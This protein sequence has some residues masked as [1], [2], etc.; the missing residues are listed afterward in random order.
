M[1]APE[2]PGT[3]IFC[4]DLEFLGT[5]EDALR[6]GAVEVADR[7]TDH[8]YVDDLLRVTLLRIARNRQRI[9]QRDHRDGARIVGN[10][11]RGKILIRRAGPVE[12]TRHGRAVDHLRALG[13]QRES[14]PGRYALDVLVELVSEKPGGVE[15]GRSLVAKS[16]GPCRK[17]GHRTAFVGDAAFD[18]DDIGIVEGELLADGEILIGI[19]EG[20]FLAV[21]ARPRTA[22]IRVFS[23]RRRVVG[24]QRKRIAILRRGG[25]VD[26]VERPALGVVIEFLE[27][28]RFYLTAAIG[29][30]DAV[31]IVLDDGFGLAAGLLGH[32]NAEAV[33]AD[34]GCGR[35]I[36]GGRHR[37]LRSLELRS[38]SA[39]GAA[40]AVG[41][42]FFSNGCIASMT[43]N[44][45]RKIRIS[46]RSLPGS[47]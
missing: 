14:A 1:S 36:R 17:R 26:Q 24:P 35:G 44:V 22:P 45:T 5:D 12:R 29:E 19:F 16:R 39:A 47:C 46:R 18:A 6:S 42:Y 7:G 9:V 37:V 21:S 4:E 3:G 11:Y 41:K 43:T 8:V 33:T 20:Q 38:S 10:E 40:G 27:D 31:Q 13:E 34:C 23:R 15:R 28:P 25:R 30:G 32:S 2:T